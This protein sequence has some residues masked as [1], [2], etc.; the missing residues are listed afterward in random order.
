LRW[1]LD[2]LASAIRLFRNGHRDTADTRL[3]WEGLAPRLE[4]LPRWLDLL[5][6]PAGGLTDSELALRRVAAGDQ[7][8]PG[9]PGPGVTKRGLGERERGQARGAD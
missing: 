2:D 8:H 5:S 9:Y 4:R 6:Q 7:L 1:Y 3:W